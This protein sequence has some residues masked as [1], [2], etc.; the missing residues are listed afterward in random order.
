V[1]DADI[2][3]RDYPRRKPDPMIFQTAAHELGLEPAD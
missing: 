3:G 2:S 1:F